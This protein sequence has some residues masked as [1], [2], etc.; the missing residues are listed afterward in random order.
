MIAKKKKQIAWAAG[1][2]AGA[3]TLLSDLGG[4]YTA[5]KD[6][7]SAAYGLHV[8]ILWSLA[9]L[10]PLGWLAYLAM[11]QHRPHAADVVSIDNAGEFF[12]KI[13]GQ[14]TS[15]KRDIIAVGLEKD[16]VFPLVISIAIARSRNREIS[17]AYF[18]EFHERYKLLELLGCNVVKLLS[19]KER[20]RFCGVLSDA[21]DILNCR[22]TVRTARKS[23]AIYGRHYFSALDFGVISAS[24]SHLRALLRGV[25]PSPTPP[26]ENK[27]VPQFVEV[28]ESEVLSR[29]KAVRF[30]DRAQ[31]SFQDVSVADTHPVSSFV[32]RFKLNQVKDII[33]LYEEKGWALF[34]PSGITLS[35]GKTSILVPPIL[36][37]H[38]GAF[39]V[40]EGHTR[41]FALRDMGIRTVRAVLIR[42]VSAELPMTPTTWRKV[43]VLSEKREKGNPQLARYIE[44][45]MHAGV[46][47]EATGGPTV[48]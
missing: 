32:S 42:G 24:T 21:D 20:D 48:T 9:L 10:P 22:A 45:G 11:R 25:S 7:L 37:E 43:S 28:A 47:G 16:W 40:A 3:I 8:S 33:R 4:A 14:L 36:E 2:G 29:L 18:Q 17:V 15:A 1:I 13:Q 26:V 27:Y 38:D 19:D 35:N 31:F 6:S 44:T 39:Y 23:E 46:W 12:E 41:L 5:V 30:Y 34:R